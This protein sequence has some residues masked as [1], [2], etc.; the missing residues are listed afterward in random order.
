MFETEI[1]A[2]I[3]GIKVKAEAPDGVVTRICT[4]SLVREFDAVVAAGLGGDARKALAALEGGGM[5]SC[6]LPIDSLLCEARLNAEGDS[7]A[8]R[9]IKG[10]KATGKAGEPEEDRPPRVELE[11]QFI[12][13]EQA[14]AFLGRHV[15]A[16]ATLR[17]NRVQLELGGLAGAE[18]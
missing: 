2:A 3:K 16:T 12:F 11:F 1:V 7:L 15:G 4:M 5:T 9:R 6:V 10:T 14:W 13:D 17:L 18:A 8:I